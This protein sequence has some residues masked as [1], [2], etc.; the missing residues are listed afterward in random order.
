MATRVTDDF[1][2]ES[3]SALSSLSPKTEALKSVVSG[4][5]FPS[6]ASTSPTFLL[7]V[8]WI[9]SKAMFADLETFEEHEAQFKVRR[10]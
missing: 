1:L 3:V 7:T 2:V 10:L 9:D 8:H 5:I 6:M 4:N